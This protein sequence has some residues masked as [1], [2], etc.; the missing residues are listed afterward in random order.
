MNKLLLVAVLLYGHASYSNVKGRI[1]IL[2]NPGAH[3]IEKVYCDTPASSAGLR[4]RD[5]VIKY[6]SDEIRGES[7]TF[8]TL[9]VK[10]GN[11]ILTFI[12]ER[13]P[14]TDIN[15]KCWIKE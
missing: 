5:K 4:H 7:G 2:Y 14:A 6:D 13:V 15:E 1:G 3:T 8:V 10:R 11:E 9:T 12:I